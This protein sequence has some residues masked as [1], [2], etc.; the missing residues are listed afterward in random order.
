MILE[1]KSLCM[2][3]GPVQYIYKQLQNIFVAKEQKEVRIFP[4]IN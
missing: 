2:R 1:E 3:V 4:D